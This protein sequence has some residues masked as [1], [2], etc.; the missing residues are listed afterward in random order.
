MLS[1]NNNCNNFIV[2]VTMLDVILELIIINH[3]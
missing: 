2:I 1:Y 3:Y